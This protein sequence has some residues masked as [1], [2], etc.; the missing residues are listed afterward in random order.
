[1]PDSAVLFIIYNR[2]DT[3][4]KVFDAIRQAQPCRLYIAADAHR[5]DHSSDAEKCKAAR[6]V[7]EEIDWPCEVKR[8]YQVQNLGCSKG[9]I[10]AF[11][12]FFTYEEEG[13]ILE[14]D[15]VPHPS[16]FPFCIELLDR[17]RN[18]KRIMLISGC[19]LG[20]HLNTGESY[21][22]S[23][24]P[25]MWGWATW[26]RRETMID[27]EL[28]EWA[29]EKHKLLFTYK[30]FKNSLFDFDLN[31]FKYWIDKFD[32]TVNKPIISWWD[33][34]W[35]YFQTKNKMA[36]VFPAS[37]LITNIGFND[38][39]THTKEPTNPAAQLVLGEMKFPL[40]H[41]KKIKRNI[42]YEENFLKWKLF[43]HK[44]LPWHFIQD[45]I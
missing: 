35:I 37:N 15:C 33:Y 29:S 11:K 27:Y 1:M 36:S 6:A 34:Q 32:L 28:K 13:I 30:A 22:F 16:F 45:I 44:R 41:P 42:D 21:G 31:W 24:V 2:P 9:P 3:T 4:Q 39:A 19:N 38:E 7:T 12:W 20:Y 23:R 43:Y 26:K 40:V 8:L 10:T 17:Y 25:N 14:D 18:N 5:H